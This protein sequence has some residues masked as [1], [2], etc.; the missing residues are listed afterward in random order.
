[1]S[2]DKPASS[3]ACGAAAPS[4]P[5][6]SECLTEYRAPCTSAATAVNYPASV[7]CTLGLQDPRSHSRPVSTNLAAAALLSRG[8]CASRW[9]RAPCLA[10]RPL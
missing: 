8:V 9:D 2:E 3:Q 10:H 7:P 1:M 4:S 5:G 6:L